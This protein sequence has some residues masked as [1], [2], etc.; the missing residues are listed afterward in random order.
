MTRSG[1]S[2]SRESRARRAIKAAFLALAVFAVLM[3]GFSWF[4]DLYCLARPPAHPEKPWIQSSPLT[5]HGENASIGSC[6]ISR[7]DGILRMNLAGDPFA[8][9]Y[10]NARLTQRYL[11]EQEENILSTVKR[12]VPSVAK[13]WLLKKFV[14]WMYRDLPEYVAPDYQM[15]LFGL[16]RGYNDPFPEVG[17]LYQRL[18]LYHAAGDISHAVVDNPLVGCT[19]FAAWGRMTQDG[20]L[21]VGRNFDL[22]AGKSFDENKIVMRVRPDE[23]L[24]Y[25]SVAWAGMTGVVSGM[26]DAG[27]AV[28]I[29]AARSS[30]KRRIGSPV[31]FVVRDVLQHAETL[32]KA[33]DIIKNSRV[34][35]SDCYVVA[36][37][38]AQTAVIVEK[39]P[40]RFSV[41]APD[42]QYIICSNH[43]L[44]KDLKDDEGNQ[45]YMSE[46]TT[47]DRY[48]RMEALVQQ[49]AGAITP[50]AAA[51]ILRDREV[52]G[53]SVGYG[54]EA[55]VNSL[56][57]SHSVIMDVSEGIVWV[58]A[59]PHQ[60]GAY[61]PF[62]LVKF[63]GPAGGR[64]IPADPILEDGTYEKYTKSLDYLTKAGKL[65]KDDNL[66]GAA[67]NAWMAQALNPDSYLPWLLMG[68]LALESGNNKE[69]RDYFLKSREHYPPYRSEREEIRAR[70][71]KLQSLPGSGEF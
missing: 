24:G 35:V 22:N 56:T 70:L 11:G 52:P 9:G 13:R 17:P 16:T 37:R 25:I 6:W 58:A 53:H 69:A 2:Q 59:Y 60:L 34:F 65:M 48:K 15:E 64:I 21:I 19:T 31:S 39:T 55:A 40:N 67:E 45:K 12:F 20:H 49:H 1:V 33:V 71:E 63:E 14:Y 10:A 68:R 32:D 47:V 27:I 5:R 54:N 61:V 8:L 57:A 4:I 38:K 66:K 26:N 7:K 3:A 36:S 43:F 42:G 41:R 23:G 28:T 62:G 51:R 44:S 29:N 46:G 30:E 18:L 50:E